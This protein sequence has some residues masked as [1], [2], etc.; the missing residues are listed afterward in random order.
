[1]NIH[2]IFIGLMVLLLNACSTDDS[3][4]SQPQSAASAYY[5]VDES[6][7]KIRDDFNAMEDK[8]RLVFISGPSCGICLRGMDDLN[9]SIVA[10]LQTDARA[11]TMVLHVP[12][13][14]AKEKHVAAAVPLMQ[15][16]RVS[17]Y[18]DEQGGSGLEFQETL[19]IPMYA[20]D[21]WMMYEPGARWEQGSPPPE[22][23][24][25]QHQLPGLPKDQS[26]DAEQFASQ[27]Q[28]SLAKQPRVEA[29]ATLPSITANSD[30]LSVAQP[31]S[32][33]IRQHHRGRGGYKNIKS[34]S[35]ITYTGQ[36]L[37]NDQTYP[38]SVTTRRPNNYQRTT[39]DGINTAIR[40]WGGETEVHQGSVAALPNDIQ[41]ELLASYDFDGW[42]TDW[43]SK[44]YQ[45]KR[46]GMVK[47]KDKLPWLMAVTLNNGR[48]WHVYVDSHTGDAFR[49]AL[50]GPDGK[51]MIALEFDD[52]RDVDGF[53]LPY[54]T[55]YFH[56][57]KLVAVDQYDQV[58][59][60]IEAEEQGA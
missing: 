41:V 14:G 42:M 28:A 34:I 35:A 10:E 16:P 45:T 38:V 12:A 1:M 50:I 57:E 5:V 24:F 20:W 22:P 4:Q 40:A 11:H 6:L 46:L 43:K 53:R 47:Y 59:V 31:S 49:Q 3:S 13:L 23:V 39:S 27:V 9:Q 60:I 19:D 55:N 33:I 32:Y 21:I 18:W 25:W 37:I 36:T 17:H 29:V 26:L 51:E 8:L 44:G 30:I 2:S 48:T 52:Y 54:Q 7:Q 56:G 15:G 58:D